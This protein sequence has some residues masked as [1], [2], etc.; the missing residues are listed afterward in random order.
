M[1][2]RSGFVSNSSSSSFII[3]IGIVEDVSTYKHD[4]AEIVTIGALRECDKQSQ[5][6]YQEC[7]KEKASGTRRY[8]WSPENN[9]NVRGEREY[10]RT[11]AFDDSEVSLDITGMSDDTTVAIL[12]T[13]GELDGDHDFCDDEDDYEPDYSLSPTEQDYEVMSDFETG[14]KSS[15]CYG[16]AGRNG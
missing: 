10:I 4:D 3:G 6:R 8:C 12:S 16:G 5:I 1:K 9:I 2:C 14:L 11:T 15:E 13:G 7:L